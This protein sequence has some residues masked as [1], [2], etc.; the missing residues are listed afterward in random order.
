M[1]KLRRWFKK[2]FI[3]HKENNHAPHF[4]RHRSMLVV[5]VAVII[6]ELGLLLQV[7]VV[8]DKTGFLASVLPGI[9]T[10]LTNE[11]RLDNDVEPL[12]E[13]ELLVQAAKLK[14]EDM[15]TYG[16]FS[17]TSPDGKTPW[18]WLEAGENLAVNFTESSDV[19]EAWMNSPSHRANIVKN[20]YTEIGIA[21]ASGT[22]EG[23]NA[24]FV[25][26]FFGTP[27]A[28]TR[29]ATVL[30]EQVAPRPATPTTS[31]K[32]GFVGNIKTFIQRIFT[33][34]KQYVSILYGGIIFLIVLTFAF[35]LHARSNARHPLLVLR[36]ILVMS[37]LLLLMSLNSKLLDKRAEVPDENTS[38]NV[39][40][41]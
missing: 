38:A 8:L 24:I 37:V 36:G 3:P 15:A 22:Y 19:T 14:A 32:V 23:R 20:D 26:Q 31:D 35:L 10:S 18:S 40:S 7:F 12:T 21:V 27:A 17:H 9:L 28:V 29:P 6:L 2:Y 1:K 34:P 5:L 11:K 4:L 33:S 13:N 25:A 39:I 30:G 16:Y 41:Y